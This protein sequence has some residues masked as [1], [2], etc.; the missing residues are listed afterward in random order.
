MGYAECEQQKNK[1]VFSQNLDLVDRGILCVVR[2]ARKH[3]CT[4]GNERLYLSVT[5]TSQ[6]GK[7]DLHKVFSQNLDLPK[8]DTRSQ[9]NTYLGTFQIRQQKCYRVDLLS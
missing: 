5:Q 7:N 2:N 1:K 8:N 6:R 4:L 9:R 3:T